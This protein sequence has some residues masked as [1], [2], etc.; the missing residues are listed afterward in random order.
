MVRVFALIGALVVFPAA[1][2]AQQ[3]CTTDARHIVNEIYRH[4]LERAPDPN[5]A[6]W[7]DRL[8]SG[9]SNVHDTVRAVV[10]SPEHMQRFGQ[11]ASEDAVATMYRHILGRQPDAEGLRGYTRVA[12]NRGMQVVAEEIL[13]SQEYQQTYGA[14]GVPGSGGLRFCAPGNV[15][16]NRST[17]TSGTRSLPMRFRGLDRDGDGMISRSEWRG[18][19]RAFQ[20]HD[21]NGDGMLS[22]DEVRVARDDYDADEFD[23]SNDHRFDYLDVNGNGRVEHSEWDGSDEAFE[24]FD[25]NNDNRLSRQELT[26]ARNATFAKLD[27]NRDGR[28]SLSEW[29][30]SRR[31]FNA[32]DENRDGVISRNEFREGAVPTTGTF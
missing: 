27:A 8:S 11:S 9:S 13:N 22:G 5:S 32:Q 16:A 12:Q 17:G 6:G 31:S 24:S 3:P 18:N 14:W 29:H 10:M 30:W 20:V 26:V 7:V 15:T 2:Q 1:A 19:D 28:I 25:R 21:R 23:A 4:V